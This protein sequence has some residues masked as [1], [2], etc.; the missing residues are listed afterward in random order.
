MYQIHKR[1]YKAEPV[2]RAYIPKSDGSKRPLGVPSIIERGIQGATSIV[3]EQ[4]YEQDFL[5]CSLGF[6]PKRGCHNA[7]A[8]LSHSIWREKM[9][10]ALEVDIRDF[11]G[12]LNHGWLLRFL[13]HRI[14]D[15]RILD[16]IKSWLK[17][18]VLEDGRHLESTDDGSVQ[19]GSISPL[20]ANVYLHYVLDLWFEH[21]MKKQLR[22]KARLIRYA[23]DFVIMFEKAEDI[24]STEKLLKIRLKEFGL[25][26]AENKT[27]RTDLRLRQRKGEDRRCISFLG[28]EVYQEKSRSEKHEKVT[29]K[30]QSSRLSRS[31]LKLKETMK[32][33][34]HWNIESQAKQINLTLKGHYNYYGLPGNS[35]TISKFHYHTIR[36]WRQHLSRRS[37]R[38]QLSWEKFQRIL[39]T[40]KLAPPRLR[41]GYRDIDQYVML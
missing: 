2:R 5:N 18:G 19:G 32:E 31:K 29:F 17:A 25:S 11:F 8:T 6:R 16:L 9:N 21:V 30:T 13:A 41:L 39:E 15:P 35:K 36:M 24:E 20:L 37:Q 38:G 10:F 3:L 28:F 23:D 22:G 34:M 14:S 40:H 1:S 4:I 26:V 27:H 12:S 33:M 7:L